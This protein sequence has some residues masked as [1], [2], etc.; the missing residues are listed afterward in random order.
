[1]GKEMSEKTGTRNWTPYENAIASA[2][3]RYAVVTIYERA[4]ITTDNGKTVWRQNVVGKKVMDDK[5]RIAYFDDTVRP[6]APS[7]V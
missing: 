4:E 1:M 3:D 2:P 5:L 6:F 7:V